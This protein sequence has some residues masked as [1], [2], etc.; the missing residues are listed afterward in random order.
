[1]AQI[2]LVHIPYKGVGPALADLIG[3]HIDLMFADVHLVLPHAKAAKLRVLA[4]TSRERSSV[5][6]QAPTVSEAGVVGFAA[7]TWFGVLAPAGTPS[8]IVARLNAEIGKILTSAT[9]RERLLTQGIEPHA[10]TPAELAAHLRNEIEK[11]RK[12]AGTAKIAID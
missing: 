7:G 5:M 2:D 10:S 3:G 6:P 12:L 8:E 11:W 4:V 9:L 1:M